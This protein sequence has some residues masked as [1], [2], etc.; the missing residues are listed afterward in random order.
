LKSVKML[1]TTKVWLLCRFNVGSPVPSSVTVRKAVASANIRLNG[2]P[3]VVGDSG[4]NSL[5]FVSRSATR[6]SEPMVKVGRW[7]EVQPMDVN[8]A[9]PIVTAALFVGVTCVP[10]L[11]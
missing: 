7:H 2:L 6:R 11:K 10:G 3:D 8:V 9:R 4:L 1:R 5:K